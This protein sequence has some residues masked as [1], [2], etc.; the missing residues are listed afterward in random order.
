MFTRITRMQ[1]NY[2]IKVN[3]EQLHREF[4]SLL[5]LEDKQA[6][7]INDS[8]MGGHRYIINI[9]QFPDHYCRPG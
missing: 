8:Y 2:D 1:E 4:Y 6:L 9:K 3:F 5:S 7:N